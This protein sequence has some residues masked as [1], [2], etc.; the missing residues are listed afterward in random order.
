MTTGKAV[1]SSREKKLMGRYNGRAPHLRYLAL[2]ALITISAL[3][4]CSPLVS[5]ARAASAPFAPPGA[6]L[7]VSPTN[8]AGCG[9]CI[10]TATNQSPTRSLT[11]SASSSGIRGVTITPAGGTL[12][13]REHLSVTIA[14]PSTI[15]CPASDTIIFTGPVN[16]VRVLWSCQATPTPTPTPSPTPTPATPTPTPVTPIPTPTTAP[17]PSPTPAA[18]MTPTGSSLT[19]T[20]TP[21][22]ASGG[23][24]GTGTPPASGGSQGSSLPSILL[25]VTALL[26]ALLACSLYLIPS[27]RHSL[28]KRL[29]SL[30]VPV[31]F[32]RR[33]DQNH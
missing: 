13:P 21:V 9:H 31:W 24:Q 16:S 14:V 19:P 5:G 1:R 32:L 12:S 3:A 23:Q 18:S 10:V 22:P 33:L 26:L 7:A 20:A 6:V 17:A 29:L 8:L 25:S 27:S 28:R 30:I 4:L 2:F 11:W 15:T